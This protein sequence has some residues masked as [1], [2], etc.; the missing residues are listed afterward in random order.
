MSSKKRLFI[1]MIAN[2]LAFV[3]QF[4]INFFLTPYI[5]STLGSE[6]YGFIPMINTITGYATIL[7]VALDSMSARFIT[8]EF[9][10]KNIEK[11]NIYYNSVLIAD[12]V[13]ALLLSVPAVF[14]ILN[15]NN[16][17]NIPLR[18]LADVQLTFS[19]TFL[20]FFINLFFAVIGVC[21]YIKN[22]VDLSAKR[23]I[24]ANVIRAIFLIVL[25]SILNPRIYFI[26]FTGLMVTIYTVACNF[27]YNRKLTPELTIDTSKFRLS[28]V[29]EMLAS[30][31][32]NSISQ[33]STTLLTGL[34]L[35]IANIFL[36]AVQSGEY[37]LVKTVPNFIIQF[38][39]VVLSAFV[40]EF[41]ILYAKGK[42][43]ELLDSVSFSL[44]IMG[45]CITIPICFLIVFGADF[46]HAW[47]PTQNSELL[48]NLSVLVLLPMIAMCGTEGI[49]KVYTVTNKLK[50]PALVMV[51]MGLLN[52][53]LDIAVLSF[54]NLGIWTLPIVYLFVAVVIQLGFTPIYG[55]HCLGLP[56][57]IFYKSIFRSFFC[58]AVM[59]AVCFLYRNIFHPLGWHQLIIA[60]I[61][62]SFIS[63]FIN[64][65]IAF[66]RESKK[67]VFAL[68][69]NM[70]P[71]FKYI[72]L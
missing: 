38:M 67:K 68:L 54:T 58:A 57:F 64:F 51:F 7:T 70:I 43:S 17:L 71:V 65:F 46:F 62:C 33:L 34:D 5:V 9:T 19:L 26:A 42:N 35:V 52:I 18:L 24:E 16:I 14:L 69:R 25:F 4:G 48:Q 66:D 8:I 6:A 3:V 28:A 21:F 36:G 31:V 45:Y 1:N 50:I 72:N 44:R 12:T 49:V 59:C 13:L 47:V 15:V 27:Y 60:G 29:K 39:I 61:F 11:A 37:S 56:W 23:G 41:N 63:L 20:A 32:W 10:K 30:G 22:R 55:A 2:A 53:L 40:P